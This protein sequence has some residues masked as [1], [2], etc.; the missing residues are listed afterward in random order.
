MQQLA[1][2]PRPNYSPINSGGG[3]PRSQIILIIALLLFSVAGLVSGFS[4]GALTK[5]P[6]QVTQSNTKPATTQHMD[7]QTA[8][9]TPK[10]VLA[11]V[12]ELGCPPADNTSSIY[13]SPTQLADGN[14]PYTFASH[15]VDK[16]GGKCD[17]NNQP[18]HMAGIMFKLW[19]TKHIP[20]HKVLQIPADILT[21]ADQLAQPIKG[22]IGD[23]NY[24][25][26]PNSLQFATNTP[27]LQQ[28][29]G[30]GQVNWTYKIGPDLQDGNYSLIILTDW[31]GHVYNWSWYDLIIKRQ[32]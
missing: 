24:P 31:Q 11:T 19:L 5:G 26:I 8:T 17:Q 28:S 6:Q 30:Q 20:A 27:E 18:V 23:A 12:K 21:Q 2:R 10:P 22:N 4:V 16:A 13:Q 1:S 15:A 32:A 14:T 29:N 3:I 25:E 9:P 7:S